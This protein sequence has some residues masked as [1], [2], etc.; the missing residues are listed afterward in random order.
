M[1]N[2]KKV[3]ALTLALAVIMSSMTVAFAASTNDAK[4]M[5]LKDLGLLKGVATD[6]TFDAAL[7]SEA[8]AQ[9]ALVLIGRALAWPVD[10][11]A[12]TTFE[13]VATWAAPYVAYAVEKN[14]TNGVSATQFGVETIDGK[15]MVTWFL[16]A[17]GYNFADAWTKNAELA[18]EAKL[19]VPTAT[20]R[21]NVVGLIYEALSTTPVGGTKT[22]IETI[23]GSDAAKLKLLKM[24]D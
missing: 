1:K 12:T 14:I 5:V 3:L 2:F 11:A 20:L 15:R 22:L 18:L 10:M 17:L 9:T 24:L 13:D 4:A 21:D 6:G 8:D 23:V 7:E 16:R 19:T